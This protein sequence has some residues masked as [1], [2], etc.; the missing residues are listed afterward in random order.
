[1]LPEYFAFI[2]TVIASL[3]ALQYFW[4][5]LRGKVQ[6]NRVTYFF[7]G[8]FP[9]IAFFA[10]LN[11]EISGVLWITLAMGVLPFTIVG[12]SFLNADAYW[13]V[14]KRDYMLALI[15]VVSMVLW[16]ITSNPILAIVFALVADMF[17]SLPTILKCYTN[18]YSEDWRPYAINSFGFFIGVLAIQT[19]TFSEYSFVLYFFLVTLFMAAL[20]FVRQRN[21]KD[22][23]LFNRLEH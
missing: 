23:A 19:W 7:W 15:A 5:T 12:A 18:P 21:I 4:L 10:Q 14:Q 13:E 20:I 9:L 6:P 3:G 16:Y 2:S 17:A 8:L 11:T 22:R 1:M